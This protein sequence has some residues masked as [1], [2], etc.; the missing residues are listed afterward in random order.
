MTD[1]P[2][3]SPAAQSLSKTGLIQTGERLR[4]RDVPILRDALVRLWNGPLGPIYAEVEARKSLGI[5]I[6]KP[7]DADA[8]GGLFRDRDQQTTQSAADTLFGE[9]TIVSRATLWWMSSDMTALLRTAADTIPPS[10]I[11]ATDFPSAAGL[12]V[13][14]YPIPAIDTDNPENHHLCL[15]VMEWFT[16]TRQGDDT[17]CLHIGF[18]DQS[19]RL[20][21][22]PQAGPLFFLGR[23]TW[24]FGTRFDEWTAEYEGAADTSKASLEEDRRLIQAFVLLLQQKVTA[25]EELAPDRAQRRR[26]ERQGSTVPSNVRVVNLRQQYR[27]H[28]EAESRPVDWSHRWVVGSHWRQHWHPKE[29]RHVPTLILPYVKGPKDKPLIVKETVHAVRH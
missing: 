26:S 29:G 10:I 12:V 13:F 2:L 19:R 16:D 5:D 15:T 4:P 25:V 8:T 6:P 22:E 9:Q 7:T 24:P 21:L 20:G 17:A 14:E 11:E 3:L 27:P 1:D 28:P 23:S 18:Y